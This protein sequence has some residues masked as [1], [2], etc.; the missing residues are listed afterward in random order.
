MADLRIATGL[1]LPLDIVTSTTAILAQRG[2]GKSYTAS[3]L[4]EELLD[5][6]QQVVILDPT[7]AWSGLRT[8]ADG[9]SPGYSI[10]V[11]GGDRGDLALEPGAGAQLA[12]AIASERFSCVIDLDGLTKGEEIRFAT[13][14]LETLYRKN[15]EP[16]H[17]IL[18][19]ADVFAPQR[20]GPDEARCLGAAQSIVRRGRRH[21]IGCTLITQRP[22]VLNK[23]VLS[24]ADMLVALRLSHPR[25]LAAIE[26]WV[27]V[28]ADHGQAAALIKTL[29]SLPTGE[30]WFWSPMRGLL[31]RAK[32]RA[33]RTFDS[34]RTPKAGERIAA[35]K[36]LADVDLARLGATMAAAAER[37]KENDPTALRAE[38]KKLRA[39]LAARPTPVDRAGIEREAT[40]RARRIF[41]GELR[42]TL[43]AAALA[44]DE[45]IRKVAAAAVPPSNRTGDE[46]ARAP[47]P[48]PAYTAPE[49]PRRAPSGDITGPEQ[50][51]LDALAWFDAIGIDA[52]ALSPLAFL[53]GYS[54]TSSGFEKARG[55]CRTKGLATYPSSGETSLTDAGRAIA[56]PPD[57]PRTDA[58]LQAAIL[59]KLP[60]PA[61]K[62][63]AALL[64]HRAKG[65]SAD[66]LAD[67]TGYSSSSSGFEKAR[68][69]LRSLGLATYPTTGRVAAAPAMYPEG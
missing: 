53:A 3:V 66:E 25:D 14:F 65:L 29:P 15:R 23:D 9:R 49:Q 62:L 13:A 46:L 20:P 6:D 7:G 1:T 60:G 5:A 45:A 64:P 24:Q 33:R 32:V 43:V 51:I 11:I 22:Q 30:A 39:E 26:E 35:P 16:L 54:P 63:L 58:G 50:R 47:S 69:Q 44:A 48:A 56:A 68:G 55:S 67:A 17:L 27:A 52:P 61:R 34:G 21:G 18:D 31:Q 40:A 8:S 12:E 19:E 57:V 41:D 38:V 37:A 4:A 42:A 10:P 28:H 59:A 36:V 2:A